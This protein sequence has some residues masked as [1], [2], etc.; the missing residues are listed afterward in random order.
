[1]TEQSHDKEFTA[2]LAGESDLAERYTEL[3]REEPP[4][5]V[6]A[7]ILAEARAAANIR[8]LGFGSRRGWFKPVA[9]AATI[10]LSFSLV[11]NVVVDSPTRFEQVVVESART[12][13]RLEAEHPDNEIRA[14]EM[15]HMESNQ[16]SA[17]MS[18]EQND[19]PEGLAITG[20]DSISGAD[21]AA[22]IDIGRSVQP[23]TIEARHID[24]DAAL[25]VVAEYVAA[26]D[27]SIVAGLAAAPQ[28]ESEQKLMRK[29]ERSRPATTDS[30]MSGSSEAFRDE[31]EPDKAFSPDDSP[32]ALLR[33][34]E[35]LRA[36]GDSVAAVARL[37]E[38]L[39]SYPDH[40]VSIRIRQQDN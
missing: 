21:I 26:V 7:Q 31:R 5:E 20:S 16:P 3:G 22:D 27:K 1:V 33:D 40:P 4:P 39:A 12:G 35:R 38:F 23:I 17:V 8:Q 6:D 25:L 34:I 15:R 11:M 18:K 10:L 19:V 28:M 30:A 13:I 2:F 37:D 36:S 29:A 32:E 9:L 24:R 14:L